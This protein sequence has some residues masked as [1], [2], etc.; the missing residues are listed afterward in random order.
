MTR[1]IFLSILL[2]SFFAVIAAITMSTAVISSYSTQRA[3]EELENECAVISAAVIQG[4]L[5]Y[6]EAV[7][8]GTIRVEWLS[9]GGTILFDSENGRKEDNS[10][11]DVLSCTES[12][13]DGTVIR[14]SGEQKDFGSL[15]MMNIR[16]LLITF[17]TIIL[18]ALIAAI[19]TARRIVRPVSSID[20]DRP[21]YGRN[22]KELSPLI[23]KL[24]SQ[25]RRVY[26]QTEELRYS[27]RQFSLI[28]ESMSE[29]IVVA[30]PKAVILS[31]NSGA[32]KLLE[33]QPVTEGQSIFT[34]SQSEQFRHCIQNAMGGRKSECVLSTEN[35][36]RRII[37]SP[38]S[39]SDTLNGIVVF[40]LDVTEQQ[41]LETM[42][43]EFTSNVSHELKTPLTTIYGIAD[44]LANEMVRPEDV[45]TFGGDIRHE[46]QRLINLI[47]DIISLSKLDENSVPRQDEEIDLYELAED[48]IARLSKSAAERNVTPY[49]M[50]E[51]VTVTGNLTIME[52]MLGNLCDNAVKYNVPG[53]SYTVSISHVPTKAVITVRDTGIGIPEEHIDRI[54]E[55]FYR[56]DKSRSRKVSG[57]GLGLSIVKH[58]VMYHGGT[59]RAESGDEGTV[60]TVELPCHKT[61][62]SK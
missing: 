37:A 34:L 54:F 49:L 7:D 38:A 42:R 8:T 32:Y 24:R 13:P 31:C 40:V 9:A 59:I 20:P 48:V 25:N 47:G 6:L 10:K 27:R 55:R 43:R 2:T 62:T 23:E 5:E 41:K 61:D 28:T 22:Y 14:V 36:D 58:G 12:L 29:G 3:A 60:F 17:T 26:R 39:I 4:G 1:K 51:H 18:F 33:A 46:A 30:D 44:M 45:S 56:A 15:M 16:P 52:E 50:G 35:G 19:I 53:G 21:G 57:T 11:G